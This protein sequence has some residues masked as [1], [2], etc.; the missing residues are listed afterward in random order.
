MLFADARLRCSGH[1]V[2]SRRRFLTGVAIGLAPIGAPAHAQEYKAQQSGKVPR[3]G[4]LVVSEPVSP[5]DP[6]V[7]AFRQGL[8]ELGYLEGQNIVV[9]YRYAHGRT[10]RAPELVAGLIGLKPDVVVASGPTALA[11]KNATQAIPIVFIATGEPVGY[12]LVASVARPGGN[13]TGL[14]LIVDAGFMGKWVELLKEAAP[15]ISRVGWLHDLNMPIS[16]LYQSDLQTAAAGRGLKFRYVEV[17]E[18]GEIDSVFAAMGKERGGF[19]VPPQ[20][21]FLTHRDRIVAFAAKHRVPAIYGFRA[22]ADAGGLMSYGLNLP[23]LWR[24]AATYVDKILKGAKPG[25]LPVEQPTKF[26]LVINLKTAK[27]LGLTIPPSLLARA[28]EVIE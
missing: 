25:D 23:D 21:F 24:R 17:H 14:A 11:A 10:E 2:I 15:R 20:P 7:G 19:I 13:A 18:V 27:V 9:E 6:N 12:G 4:V 28:D 16:T 5:T 26:E 3:I 1:T 8:R 22:F